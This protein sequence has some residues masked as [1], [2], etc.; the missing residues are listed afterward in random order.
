MH[1]YC[2]PPAKS[3]V[4]PDSTGGDFGNDQA[5]FAQRCTARTIVSSACRKRFLS[6]AVKPAL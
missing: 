4:F 5:P 3:L 6:R 2:H 1:R